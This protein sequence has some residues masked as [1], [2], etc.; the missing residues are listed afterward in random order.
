MKFIRAC[1]LRNYEFRFEIMNL[2]ISGYSLY[3]LSMKRT[4]IHLFIY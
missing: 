2:W 4:F 3:G 1:V